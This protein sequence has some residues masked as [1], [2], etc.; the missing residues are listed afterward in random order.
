MSVLKQDSRKRMML[1]QDGNS[2]TFLLIFNA[3]IFVLLKFA[4]VIY[5]LTDS[6]IPQFENEVLSWVAM[7]ANPSFFAT[8]PWTLLLSMFAHVRLW[9][10]FSNLLW[11]W[12][13]GYILHDLVGNKKLFPLYLYGGLAGAI[14]FI[15]TANLVPSLRAN[16]ADINPLLGAGPS[17]MCI[18]V[19]VTA[20][21]PKY[22]IFPMINGGIPLWILTAL[23]III[24]FAAVGISNWSYA[25]ALIAAG[26]VG[27]IFVHQLQK[28]ND[29]GAWMSDFVNWLDDLFNPEKKYTEEAIKKRSFYKSKEKPFEKIPKITAERVDELLDK[30]NQ[31]GYNSLTEEEKV[32]L[33]KA[34]KEEL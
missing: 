27:Y 10:I 3:I 28:G 30:I 22:K 26:G 14:A 8:R 15:L 7:P 2:L 5:L 17:L 9:H 11:L 6:T 21:S 24:N 18:A 31:K 23:F 12:T 13:F 29:L 19:G 1:G 32:F 16:L 34:S 4:M 20:I 25:A 33:K